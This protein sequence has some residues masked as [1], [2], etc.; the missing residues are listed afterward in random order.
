MYHIRNEGFRYMTDAQLDRLLHSMSID[1]KVFQLSQLP[2][3]FYDQG[4]Q[5]P[6][7]D[8]Q[9]A[10]SREHMHQM[11]SILYIFDAASSRKV[12]ENVIR[13]QPHHI[14]LLFMM[15]VIHG[16]KTIF[17]IPLAQAG[18][19]DMDLIS[20][21]AS[22]AAG[23]ASEAGIHVVFSPMVDLVRDPRWGRVMESAGEDPFL[24]AKVGEAMVR[25]YQGPRE[26]GKFVS[27]CFKHFAAYGGASGGRDYNTVELSEHTLRTFYLPAY[28]AAV[29][30][31]CD[32]AMTS[33]NVLNGLPSSGNPWLLTKVLREEW[34]FEGVV[35]SDWNAIGE[36]VEHGVCKNLKEAALMAFRAGVDIDMCSFAYAKHLSELVA[37][38]EISEQMLDR[39]VMRVLKLKNKHGLFEDPYKTIR[40]AAPSGPSQRSLARQSVCE[41]MVLLKNSGA[42]PLLPLTKGTKAALVGPFVFTSS[43]LSSWAPTGDEVDVVTVFQ[44]AEEISS[45]YRFTYAKGCVLNT[46]DDY[47]PQSDEAS[48]QA[49]REGVPVH[50]NLSGD[51]GDPLLPE[52]L[53]VAADADVVIACIGEHPRMSGE[54]ASRGDIR[55]PQ[56]QMDLLKQLWNV[57][58]NI[59][60]VVFAGRPL[61]LREVC[62]YSRSIVYAW[63]PGTEGGH[64]V[65]D[66]LT[67]AYNPSGKLT[68]S[69]PY[70]LG[71]VP[72]YYNNYNTGRP[73]VDPQGVFYTSAY[74]DIPNAPLY[75]FGYGL[76]YTEFQYGPVQLSADTMTAGEQIEASVELTNTGEYT[77]TEVVQLY[78]RD[79]VGS[80][81]RPRRMLKDFQRVTLKP[82][83]SC[84]VKFRIDEKMLTLYRPDMKLVSEPGDFEVYIGTDSDTKNK[85][86][87]SLLEK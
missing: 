56:P 54:G 61:D 34:G 13:A 26:D 86:R 20:R 60:T 38:G 71:Q 64:G 6:G 32:M 24:G 47:R 55:V 57:N 78:L 4:L 58:N 39:S 8:V 51:Q 76:S 49:I 22:A 30:A 52:A 41:S 79:L 46:R 42:S 63:L 73:K 69:I 53:S 82:G 21:S 77:G 72:V 83:E 65:M 40:E 43:L 81:V 48:I 25:G 7:T 75:P 35:I 31:G 3:T 67:G 17:P 45:D 16:F 66:V 37:E 18:S 85:G 70:S 62:R 80:T 23:E 33:F 15:D 11:G 36:L 10:V 2:P 5:I 50:L 19:F 74:N 28:E 68:M 14:P 84:R 59:V 44:A 9:E 1:E 27:G 87:F 29:R 12:Q